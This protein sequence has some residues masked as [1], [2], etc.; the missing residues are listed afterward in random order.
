MF[1]S[2]GGATFLW[3]AVMVFL[4]PDTPM[5]GYF[6]AKEDR[7]KAVLRVRE[8][9]T[10]IKSQVY[11]NKQF[12]EALCDPAAW[13]LVLFVVGTTIFGGGVAAFLPLVIRGMG[14]STLNTYLLQMVVVLVSAVSV[15]AATA[16]AS[17]LKNARTLIMAVCYL[18]GLAGLIMVRQ[19]PASMRAARFGGIC[20]ASIFT[21]AVVL[22]FSLSASNVG[23]FTK[24]NT[25]NGM[26]SIRG[27][28]SLTILS[29]CKLDSTTNRLVRIDL[30]RDL[31]RQHCGSPDLSLQG[32]PNLPIWLPGQH[33]LHWCFSLLR[34]GSAHIL[35]VGEQSA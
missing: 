7:L 25:V 34:L 27:I 30:Y 31:R 32:S 35:R 17:Y 20:L 22:A 15:L 5:T 33:H 18:I 6:L 16:A 3:G 24:K 29:F 12:I 10:G 23:G 9:R 28:P 8:N 13:L 11:K 26:V 4:L 14:F 1:L 2:F 19:L 21:P